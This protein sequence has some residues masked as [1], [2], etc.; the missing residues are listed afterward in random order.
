MK[1]L[2]FSLVT[3]ILLT[4]FYFQLPKNISTEEITHET[5]DIDK[6]DIEYKNIS[7][8]PTL[9]ETDKQIYKNLIPISLNESLQV[10]ASVADSSIERQLG[11][12]N[13]PYLPEYVVKLFVFEDIAIRNFWMK[14][15]NYSIDIVWLDEN[16]KVISVTENLLPESYHDRETFSSEVP[17]KYVIETVPGLFLKHNIEVGSVIKF[18]I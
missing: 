11:L 18:D 4:V 7:E 6:A 1:I 3:A 14:D 5:V 12:S 13:T 8:L 15:M 9:T 17:A 16:K 10:W 2:L